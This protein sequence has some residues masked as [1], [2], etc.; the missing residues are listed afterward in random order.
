[1]AKKESRK[2]VLGAFKKTLAWVGRIVGS[3]LLIILT[4]SAIL[5]VIGAVYID[6]HLGEQ[7][8]GFNLREYQLD[9]SSTI[10]HRDASGQ[11]V[12]LEQLAGI[13]HRVWARYEE[14]PRHLVQAAIAIEDQRFLEHNGV[15]WRRTV[16]GFLTMM[17][18]GSQFGG[19]TITQQVI[20]NLTE[21]DEVTVTRKLNE[22]MLA[23][24]VE[25]SH[26]KADI[27]ELYLN[28]IYLSQGNYGI[29]TAA[30]FYFGI[31]DLQE[32][33]IAQSAAL[34]GITNMPAFFCPI[35][36][37]ENNRARQ[38]TILYTMR[39]QGF[40]TQQEYEEAWDEELEFQTNRGLR[41]GG[42]ERPVHATYVDQVIVDV[43]R[44]LAEERGI[45]INEARQLIFTAGFN[46]HISMDMDV[47]RTLE[48][49]FQDDASFPNVRSLD[50]PQ[51]AMTIIEPGTGRI[52]GMAG[53]RGEREGRMILNR[54]VSRRSPG[55]AIKPM[56][57]FAPALEFHGMNPYSP[58]LDAPLRLNARGQMWPQNSTSLPG[59][60]GQMLGNMTMTDAFAFSINTPTVRTLHD[61]IG[62]NEAFEFMTSDTAG[63]G[64]NL[65]SE[66][67]GFTDI[68]YSPLALGGFTRGVTTVEM[69]ASAATFVNR[70]IFNEPRTFEYVVNSRGEIILDNRANVGRAVVSEST[71]WYINYMMVDAVRRG[72]APA[73]RNGA[74]GENLANIPVGGK[75]G[76]T[77]NNFD[78]YF[79]GYTPYF[80]GAVWF[81]FDEPQEIRLDFT[82]NPSVHLWRNVMGR[83]HAGRSR[84]FGNLVSETQ[85]FFELPTEQV[86]ICL[87]S[88][89]LAGAACREDPRGGRV[90]T[91]TLVAS[92]VPEDTCEVHQSIH[93]CRQTGN[94]ATA[95]CSSTRRIGVLALSRQFPMR[96]VNL[97][98][99]AFVLHSAREAL[100][101]GYHYA[102]GRG[103][104]NNQC[105]GC[106]AAPP[107]APDPTP[108]P[109]APAATPTPPAAPSPTPPPA[110]PSPTP[111]PEP[112]SPTPPPEPSPPPPPDDD[113]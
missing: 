40:I 55:S 19:S 108:T 62:L 61:I 66:D 32:L 67:G 79:V 93:V 45:P 65:V 73:A 91:V 82:H 16:G 30:Y 77:D 56:S 58:M 6:R 48:E 46:I 34:V 3:L 13:E 71:A 2:D 49:I 50:I 36:N 95:S 94:R 35:R 84:S 24:E 27:M 104:F 72:T 60:R 89:K 33:T 20:K 80:V 87:D 68:G 92:A 18:G 53:G 99:E 74:G 28:T 26:S 97:V 98:D 8:L 10:Y 14:F 86:A 112:P 47:Q 105:P 31:E 110:A 52:L 111:P 103:A 70:G 107:P 102:N 25:R 85:E 113:E 69:A 38:E 101:P 59:R 63:L 29:R 78:R 7:V 96:N 100:R 106:R 12:E 109:D 90:Q 57:I 42:G 23:I 11:W 75:T 51:A 21:N 43:S 9:M 5:A 41:A 1:M 17:T 64:F 76:T 22:I 44:A 37:P 88:G 4:T 81:G 15:D 54:A 39:N 83:L